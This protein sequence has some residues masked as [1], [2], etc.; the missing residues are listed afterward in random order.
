LDFHNRSNPQIAYLGWDAPAKDEAIDEAWEGLW[1]FLKSQITS[2]GFSVTSPWKTHAGIVGGQSWA[3]TLYR[4]AGDTWACAETDSL[5]LE[6]LGDQL[7]GVRRIIIVGRGV[8]GQLIAARYPD[9]TLVSGKDWESRVFTYE[10]DVIINVT[11]TDIRAPA[12]LT[13]IF[14]L[15]YEPSAGMPPRSYY[16][17][18]WFFRQAHAQQ[19]LWGWDVGAQIPKSRLDFLERHLETYEHV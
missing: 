3:N 6:W 15:R 4:C 13:P 10:S 9:A 19:M 17:Q 14:D 12:M 18:E 16:A 7:R 1:D 8:M 5:G 2:G 11:G